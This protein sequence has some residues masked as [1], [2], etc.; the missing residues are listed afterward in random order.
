MLRLKKVLNT[1]VILAEDDQ[2]KEFILFGKGIGFGKKVG[3]PVQEDQVHQVFIP[4]EHDRVKELASLL[5]TVPP[6]FAELTQQIVVHA[7][8]Q[9]RV[10]LSTSVYFTLMDH[11]NFAV[12]RFRQGINITNKVYWEI[13]NY[14]PDEFRVGTYAL[15]R[16]NEALSIEL[17]VE[18]A[19]N[20]AFHLIN[21]QGEQGESSNG[22]GVRYAK[23]VA[24]IVNLARYNF[25]LDLETDNVHYTRFITH[26]KF[27]A[28]RFFS[29]QM[30]QESDNA[31]FDQIAGLYPQ[32]MLG[33]LKI[34]DY[35]EQVYGKTIPND[36]LA[37]LAVH[38]QRLMRHKQ[39]EP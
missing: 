16:V 1:S 37:Y 27:F 22:N 2:H 15:Q 8:Q 29:D 18:E 12:E 33:A 13:K 11:L 23:M 26:V 39:M 7:E 9:L 5:D 32:A 21:A 14:Y 10:K 25:H 31:L 4:V 36:E 6:I 30:L 17:P 24:S 38:I 35:I 28:E 19:A 3:T 34:K 20:I